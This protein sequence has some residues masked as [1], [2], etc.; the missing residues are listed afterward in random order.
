[1]TAIALQFQDKLQEASYFRIKTQQGYF[2]AALLVQDVSIFIFAAPVISALHTNP[3]CRFS[4]ATFVNN[5]A[6]RQKQNSKFDLL[7]LEL[8]QL[9]EASTVSHAR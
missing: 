7:P 5:H 2:A 9:A 1:M 4:L 8:F 3:D 6:P